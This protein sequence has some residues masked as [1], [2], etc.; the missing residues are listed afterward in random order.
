M[1][2]NGHTLPSFEYFC[3]DAYADTIAI[4]NNVP[5]R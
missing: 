3:W 2:G 5:R 1:T 4:V